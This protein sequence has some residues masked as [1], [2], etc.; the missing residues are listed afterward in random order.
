MT[1]TATE[2][3]SNSLGPAGRMQLSNGRPQTV[4]AQ[5]EEAGA[6]EENDSVWERACSS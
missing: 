1:W 2:L 3:L 5:R 4:L 6:V